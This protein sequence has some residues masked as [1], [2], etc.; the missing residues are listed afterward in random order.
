MKYEQ[1]KKAKIELPNNNKTT[2]KKK[3][4]LGYQYFEEP[5]AN[6]FLCAKKKSG[7][8]TLIYNIIKNT[9]D[10]NTTV[11][12]FVSTFHNDETYRYIEKYLQ[13]NNI[14]YIIYTSIYYDAS[15]TKIN[16]LDSI[17]KRIELKAA[18]ES[19]KQTKIVDDDLKYIK[20]SK[21][22]NVESRKKRSS[23]YI[24]PEYLFVFDDISGELKYNLSYNTL[25]KHNRHY[26]CKTITS[27]Q[28]YKDI[29]VTVRQNID[30]LILY[31]NLSNDTLE[32][33]YDELQFDDLTFDQFKEIYLD[34]VAEPYYFLYIDTNNMELRVNFDK[35]IIVE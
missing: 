9:I 17:T 27:S 23:K 25:I 4:A 33:I 3:K 31:R 20:L 5:Y 2:K 32:S 8:T 11:I 15:N 22:S 29:P 19:N 24:V 13:K 1:L 10:K 28:G 16:L 12:F 35:K 18:S 34:V 14:N 21:I 26:K 30:Y 6:I 7:K